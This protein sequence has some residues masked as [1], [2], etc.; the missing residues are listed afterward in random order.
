[1]VDLFGFHPEINDVVVLGIFI[2]IQMIELTEPACN[3]TLATLE[4]LTSMN[5]RALP[6]SA[7]V[8]A[9]MSSERRFQGAFIEAA[10]QNP[11]DRR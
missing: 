3:R 4:S 1:M 2:F 11:Q 5:V 6:S 9:S 7:I 10:E 8:E